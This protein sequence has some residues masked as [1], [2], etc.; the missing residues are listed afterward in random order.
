MFG[1]PKSR[2]DLAKRLIGEWHAEGASGQTH[3]AIVAVFHPDG[4]FITRTHVESPMATAQTVSQA[5]RYRVEQLDPHRFK[6]YTIDENG[7][8]LSTSLRTFVDENTMV[9]E[10]GPVTFVRAR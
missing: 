3:S 5:G 1:K 9:T 8:P 6:L 2:V 7:A 10:L 4:T